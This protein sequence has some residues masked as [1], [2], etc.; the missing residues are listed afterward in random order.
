MVEIGAVTGD[1]SMKT[2]RALKNMGVMH[3]VI[4]SPNGQWGFMRLTPFG[5]AIQTI[6]KDRKR[7]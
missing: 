5:E 3:L 1:F 7:K 2:V 6:L 4:T